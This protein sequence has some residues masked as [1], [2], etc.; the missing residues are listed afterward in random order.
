MASIRANGDGL[1]RVTCDIPRCVE[2]RHERG[3]KEGRFLLSYQ[4]G[5]GTL[6][7]VVLCSGCGGTHSI[8]VPVIQKQ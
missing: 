5:Q 1:Q 8:T 4:W 6:I 7:L 3:Q 2:A